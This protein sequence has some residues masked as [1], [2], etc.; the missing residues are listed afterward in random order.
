MT[1]DT[2]LAERMDESQEYFDT[3]MIYLA[4]RDR[5][6]TAVAK[7]LQRYVPVDGAVLDLGAAYCSFINH[8]QAAE[9]HA[10]DLFPGFVEFA[11]S[12]VTAHV[13]SC[14]TLGQFEAGRFDVV[15]AS[16]L[17]EHLTRQEITS[18][19][20]EM[21]RVLRPGGRVILVQ[22]NF[23][24]CSTEY[25]DDYTHV[26][27]FTHVS[28]TDLLSASGFC[29]EKVVP[30]FMPFS[31]QSC[32]PQWSWAVALYL[33]SPIRPMAKQMLIVAAV[34]EGH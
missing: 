17:L 16:N 13:G 10:V 28:L 26:T 9:K 3:R 15:F 19:L 7:Y 21:G 1:K 23:R 18:T 27:V 8:I 2:G 32:L 25:F 24:Y 30:R 34:R 20:K 12:D 11:A 29:V 14:S 31:M 33:R 22:P 6:W 4:G 5:V